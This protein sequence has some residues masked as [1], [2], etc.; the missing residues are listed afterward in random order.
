VMTVELR[1]LLS[2]PEMS[3]AGRQA[4]R[5][6]RQLKRRPPLARTR[7]ASCGCHAQCLRCQGRPQELCGRLGDEVRSGGVVSGISMTSMPFWNLTP[8]TTFGNWFS[9]FNRRQAPGRGPTALFDPTNCR[10]RPACA[11]GREN[12]DTLSSK[13]CAAVIGSAATKATMPSELRKLMQPSRRSLIVQ[14]SQPSLPAYSP[15][16]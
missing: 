9:P 11:I 8:R 13:A 6:A 5:V 3:A 16:T 7:K 15:N 12:P 2:T 4:I 14:F 10:C 1:N